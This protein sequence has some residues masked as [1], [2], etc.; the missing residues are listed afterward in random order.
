MEEK[1][2]AP[3]QM[4][5]EIFL[6]KTLLQHMQPDRDNRLLSKLKSRASAHTR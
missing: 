2:P 4:K 1:K 6:L 3:G 5:S